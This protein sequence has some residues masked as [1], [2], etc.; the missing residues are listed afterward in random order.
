MFLMK[1]HFCLTSLKI[2][3]FLQKNLEETFYAG[4]IWDLA[5]AEEKELNY[6][7]IMN[8]S[9]EIK[10]VYLMHKSLDLQLLIS[11]AQII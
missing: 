9:M 3:N 7:L 11:M 8:Y 1:M 5:S 10:T 2:Y 4:L 6:V